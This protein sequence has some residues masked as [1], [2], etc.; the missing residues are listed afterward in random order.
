MYSTPMV[1]KPAVI[2]IRNVP[3]QVAGEF[4]ARAA[5]AGMTYAAYLAWLLEHTPATIGQETDQ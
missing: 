1:D 2:Y 5:R 3:R 4:R